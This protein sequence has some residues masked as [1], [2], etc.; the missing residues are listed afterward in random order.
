MPRYRRHEE[1]SEYHLSRVE[2]QAFLLKVELQ[3]A[4]LAL[5]PFC[6]HYDAIDRL[7]TDLRKALNL[8]NGRP[9][10]YE[11]PHAAPMSGG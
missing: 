7:H 5:K 9:A 2:R 6:P 10:D 3:A 11:R 4:Q 1:I 8:L